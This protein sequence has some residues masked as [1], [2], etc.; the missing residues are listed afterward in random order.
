VD[1]GAYHE[2]RVRR[3]LLLRGGGI[4]PRVQSYELQNVSANA[5]ALWSGL[6]VYV[7]AREVFRFRTVGALF[8]LAGFS[9]SELAYVALHGFKAQLAAMTLASP[10]PA[11]SSRRARAKRWHG[12]R[13]PPM[14]PD[15]EEALLRKSLVGQPSRSGCGFEG[16]AI[17]L[18]F[19]RLDGPVADPLGMPAVV[20]V[21]TGSS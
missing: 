18:A 7:L 15:R 1:R 8:L 19:Q 11:S 4:A 9:F 12:L 17:A 3:L 20:V 6:A 21:G 14:G 10:P 5:F 2:H 16:D 13:S